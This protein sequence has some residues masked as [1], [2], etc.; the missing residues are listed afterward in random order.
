M[1]LLINS[2]SGIPKLKWEDQKSTWKRELQN[3][4]KKKI[5]KTLSE[6]SAV[7]APK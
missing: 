6:A 5:N 4:L 3:E 1:I 7:T 2:L